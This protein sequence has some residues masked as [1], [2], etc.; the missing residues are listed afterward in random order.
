MNGNI[1]QLGEN[2]TKYQIY[3]KNSIS[4]EDIEKIGYKILSYKKVG[5]IVHAVFYDNVDIEDFK[6][7]F[8]VILFEKIAIDPDELIALQML[9]ARKE[10]E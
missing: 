10:N 3:S 5:S 7:K 6:K 4:K 9:S 1:E 2:F 8:D